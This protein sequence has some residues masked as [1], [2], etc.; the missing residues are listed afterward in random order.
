MTVSMLQF[1]LELEGVES[2]KDKRRIVSSLKEKLQL[3]FRL[4]VAEVDLQDSLRQARIGAALVSNSR[5][6]GESVLHK[7]LAFVE[8]QAPGRLADAE[9]FTEQY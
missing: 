5:R 8:R 2:I 9:I 6:F 1:R 3:R 7:A 4:S